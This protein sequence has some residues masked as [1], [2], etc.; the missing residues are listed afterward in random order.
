MGAVAGG[1]KIG[2]RMVNV[3]LA[4]QPPRAKALHECSPEEA[5]QVPVQTILEHLDATVQNEFNAGC[6]VLI[7]GKG[8]LHK[9]GAQ[10]RV[11]IRAGRTCTTTRTLGRLVCAAVSDAD[12]R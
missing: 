9:R 3:V 8:I 4:L 6:G 1:M 5:N 10:Q 12:I 2:D 11:M 7:S